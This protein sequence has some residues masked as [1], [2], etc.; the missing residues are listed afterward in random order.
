MK[1][2]LVLGAG[3]LVGHKVVFG[4][5]S[6]GYHVVAASRKKEDLFEDIS[7]THICIDIEQFDLLKDQITSYNIDVVVN[8]AAYTAVDKAETEK[9][10]CMSVNALAVEKLAKFCELKSIYLIHFSTDYVFDGRSGPYSE[11]ARPNPL[12]VYGS[13]KLAGDNAI[14]GSHPKS[15]I[16]RAVVVFGTHKNQRKLNFVTWLIQELKAGNSVKIVTDQLST[17]SYAEDLVQAVLK[18]CKS[19]NYGVY[20]ISGDEWFSRYDMSLKIAEILSLEKSL[21]FPILTAEF[22]QPAK[23]PLKSGFKVDKAKE[24]LG[25]IPTSLDDAIKQIERQLT[26]YE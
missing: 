26:G 3:G 11:T 1:N 2:V 6:E 12:S 25:F 8:C 21:I 7:C 18:L 22:N 16:L 24:K 5:H 14:L 15:T 4:L 9:E 17:Y 10:K 19:P 13:S 23:R 20:N